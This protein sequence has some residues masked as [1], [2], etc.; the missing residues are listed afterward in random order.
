M[1]RGGGR[2]AG[3]GGRGGRIH[4]ADF[5]R[6]AGESFLELHDALAKTAAHFRQALSEEDQTDRRDDD[7]C[8]ATGHAC[9]MSGLPTGRRR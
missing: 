6:D 8:S 4:L 7:P 1:G 3:G 9:E 2:R 5:F